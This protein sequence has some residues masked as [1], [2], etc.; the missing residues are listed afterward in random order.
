MG[1]KGERF[2]LRASQR[3]API[4]AS[5]TPRPIPK[6]RSVIIIPI[7][8]YISEMSLSREPRDSRESRLRLGV[9]PLAILR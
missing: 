6:N 5:M 7:I 3:S 9:D 8:F 2:P 4:D 1:A